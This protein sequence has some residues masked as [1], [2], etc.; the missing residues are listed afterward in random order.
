MD[1]T[2]F[3]RYFLGPVAMLAAILLNTWAIQVDLWPASVAWLFI[4][5]VWAGFVGGLRAAIASATLLSF[6]SAYLDPGNIERLLVVP[7]S[8]VAIAGLVG[9]RTRRWREALTAERLAWET[10]RQNERKARMVDTINGNLRLLEQAFERAERLTEGWGFMGEET[11]QAEAVK[12]RQ[13]LADLRTLAE[14]WHAMAQ[15]R[16]FMECA[17][18]LARTRALLFRAADAA[19]QLGLAY[20]EFDALIAEKK[21]IETAA[22]VK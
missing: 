1:R 5:V 4:F 20:D 6:Y 15:E 13:F 16:G 7:I 12:V 10:A 3:E 21:R 22:P 14:G 11:R 18:E 17:D 2:N 19:G 9:W 8:L